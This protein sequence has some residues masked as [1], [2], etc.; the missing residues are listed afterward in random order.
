MSRLAKILAISRIAK[1]TGNNG[2]SRI[3]QEK[4][5]NALVK[6]ITTS[7]RGT[8]PQR[9]I[10]KS[11]LSNFTKVAEEI[12]GDN[13][14]V[15]KS[16]TKLVEKWIE[17]YSAG[18]KKLIFSQYQS[19][20]QTAWFR[21]LTNDYVSNLQGRG[22]TKVQILAYM[23]DR[24]TEICQAMHGRVF[25]ISSYS[26]DPDFV[27][28]EKIESMGYGS[29]PTKDMKVMLP[30]YHFNCRTTFVTY[31]EAT[32]DF[33]KIK[34]KI[35]D[36][37]SLTSKDIKLI[38][39]SLSKAKWLS[40]GKKQ[41][42]Y[43]KHGESK[44]RSQYNQQIIDSLL[45][46]DKSYLGIN[47]GNKNLTLATFKYD[48]TDKHNVKKY[49]F[50][51]YLVK[52]KKVITSFIR[53]EEDYLANEKNKLIKLV[54][55]TPGNK[56]KVIKGLIMKENNYWNKHHS[57][58]W[59]LI[60]IEDYRE[61]YNS[62]INHFVSWYQYVP[63]EL[64]DDEDWFAELTRSIP[65]RYDIHILLM[66]DYNFTQEERNLIERTDKKLLDNID[67]YF[68]KIKVISPDELSEFLIWL[69]DAREA[70]K[71]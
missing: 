13:P 22:V 52:S 34:Q 35:Y 25:D 65:A 58:E 51:Q 3:D 56:Q 23:D 10:K 63:S 36:V 31:E 41:E 48:H 43:E 53:S 19:F 24:T 29:M 21:S 14:Q 20:S 46:Y 6:D 70:E 47:K 9:G 12:M 15:T 67:Y 50:T 66:N 57:L 45:D 2:L 61:R 54:F 59:I 26:I 69:Q 62:I 28:Y 7:P 4:L 5:F 33:D 71:N 55:I 8:H 30:P 42:H 17:P 68:K 18:Q 60:D 16:Y 64:E 32:N 38:T 37:E 49:V 1:K 27:T 11:N 39:G 40:E 44:S